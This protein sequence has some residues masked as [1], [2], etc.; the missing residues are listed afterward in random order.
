[1]RYLGRCDSIACLPRFPASE[2][3]KYALN[4][5]HA[6]YEIFA[7]FRLLRRRPASAAQRRTRDDLGLSAHAVA[8]GRLQLQASANLF[9]LCRRGDRALRAMGRR[10]DDTSTAA[11][12]PALGYIRNRQRTADKTPGRAMVPALAVRAVARC[13]RA[14]NFAAPLPNDFRIAAAPELR[15]QRRIDLMLRSGGRDQCAGKSITTITMDTTPAR[16]I[17]SPY[18]P[19]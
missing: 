18:W 12:L 17:C 4:N 5:G 9:G 16:S 11:A 3:C 15:P 14:I 10:L 8:A 7:L 2:P 19:C 13:Q 6:A 1:M